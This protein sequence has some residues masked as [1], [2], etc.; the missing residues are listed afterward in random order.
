[1]GV[2]SSLHRRGS[3]VRVPKDLDHILLKGPVTPSLPTVRKSATDRPS[4]SQQETSDY[5][6]PQC[7][8]EVAH[9]RRWVNLGLRVNDI[10]VLV[11]E[12]RRYGLL[13]IAEER[14]FALK[15]MRKS[16]ERD[17]LLAEFNEHTK[18]MGFAYA[19]NPE[20]PLKDLI[21]F[22]VMRPIVKATGF[23][24]FAELTKQKY[25]GEHK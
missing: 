18:Q 5:L 19:P 24:Y 9:R 1:L 6:N 8:L 13:H 12:S 4:F 21:V 11:E 23:A 25:G 16:Q 15:N 7:L 22:G 17:K 10:V 20:Y 3:H 2:G 14:G